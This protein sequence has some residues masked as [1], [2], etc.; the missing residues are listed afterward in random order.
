MA[1][2]DAHFST[3]SHAASPH[4]RADLRDLL[5][6]MTTKEVVINS[7]QSTSWKALREAER[8]NDET[9]LDELAALIQSSR[10]TRERKAAYFIV[11]AIGS[12][13][14]TPFSAAILLR[15]ASLEK[16]KYVLSSVLEALRKASKPNDIPLDPIYHLLD[17][18][19]WLVRHAAILALANSDAPVTEER[20]I[21]HLF[22]TKDAFDK[23]YCHVALGSIGTLR[24]LDAIEANLKSRKRDVKQSAKAAIKAIHARHDVGDQGGSI[25]AP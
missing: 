9:L 4:M 24:S 17:D 6:R 5:D 3:K 19:R 10:N 8:L 20:I 1:D 12:N 14:G 16:D 25:I 18:P 2:G 21:A 7:E 23:V 11:G 22:E 13:T 15:G